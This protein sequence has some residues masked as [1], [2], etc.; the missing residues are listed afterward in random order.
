LLLS[1]QGQIQIRFWRFLGF[2]DETMYQDDPVFLETEHNP[3]DPSVGDP[4]SDFE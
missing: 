1:L 2:F 4:A 3:R